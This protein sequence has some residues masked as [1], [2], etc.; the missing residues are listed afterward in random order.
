MGPPTQIDLKFSTLTRNKIQNSKITKVRYYHHRVPLLGRPSE[1]GN[2]VI[3]NGT[4]VTENGNVFRENGDI[5][6]ENDNIVI[7]T[8]QKLVED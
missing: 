6:T 7:K 2:I 4:I 8:K 5:V 3:E 1:N